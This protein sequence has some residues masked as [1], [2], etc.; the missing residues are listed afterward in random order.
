ML[1]NGVLRMQIGPCETFCVLFERSY[2]HFKPLLL[3]FKWGR[4]NQIYL[5]SDVDVQSRNMNVIKTHYRR[6]GV[7][8]RV[9]TFLSVV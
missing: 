1:S 6:S 2:T 4:K 3:R 5:E 7:L 9:T 8:F